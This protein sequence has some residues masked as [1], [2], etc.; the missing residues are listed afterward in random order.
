MCC[1][2]PSVKASGTRAQA[3]ITKMEGKRQ[4][5]EWALGG[6]QGLRGRRFPGLA[7]VSTWRFPQLAWVL[8]FIV[9]AAFVTVMSWKIT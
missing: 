1:L 8:L 4:M 7:W 5:E 3:Y 2:L 9:L 6:S